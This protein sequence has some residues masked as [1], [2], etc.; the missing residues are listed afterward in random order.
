MRTPKAYRKRHRHQQS[1]TSP[2]RGVN[3]MWMLLWKHPLATSQIVCEGFPGYQ[4]LRSEQLWW[5]SATF[6]KQNRR[7]VASSPGPR[8]VYRL[9]SRNPLKHNSWRPGTIH[10]G[11]R[12]GQSSEHRCDEAEPIS[13]PRGCANK[14]WTLSSRRCLPFT[15]ASG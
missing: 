15:N 5:V 7:A 1:P 2:G 9:S 11:R 14:T 8:S 12:C 13:A 3:R 10:G 4:P 6:Q